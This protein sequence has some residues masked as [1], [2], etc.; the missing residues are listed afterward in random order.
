[1]SVFFHSFLNSGTKAVPKNDA[2]SKPSQDKKVAPMAHPD[3]PAFPVGVTGILKKT[4]PLVESDFIPD[5]PSK[6]PQTVSFKEPNE[7]KYFDP[8]EEKDT[9]DALDVLPAASEALLYDL[10][11]TGLTSMDLADDIA[12]P[13]HHLTLDD[14]KKQLA[15][16]TGTDDDILNITIDV[17]P[18]PAPTIPKKE[19]HSWTVQLWKHNNVF[20]SPKKGEAKPE[21]FDKFKTALFKTAHLAFLALVDLVRWISGNGYENAFNGDS[22]LFSL[23]NSRFNTNRTY[24]WLKVE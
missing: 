11:E 4:R 1:M 13:T 21:G 6:K 10:D 7:R 14:P 17:D 24:S 19:F 12:Q 16:D 2:K 20:S 3:S 23:E 8:P 9:L 18:V 5:A 15:I 22:I